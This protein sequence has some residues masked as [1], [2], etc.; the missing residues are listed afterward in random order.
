MSPILD[1]VAYREA[2]EDL[3]AAFGDDWDAYVNHF[4]TFGASEMRDQGVLF[5]H[6]TFSALWQSREQNNRYF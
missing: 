6:Q 3:D 2:Y 4:F 5:N 1:V